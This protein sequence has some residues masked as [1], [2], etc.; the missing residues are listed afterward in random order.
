MTVP[1]QPWDSAP[2]INARIEEG[3]FKVDGLERMVFRG[4]NWKFGGCTYF[5][6]CTDCG[7]DAEAGGLVGKGKVVRWAWAH[8]CNKLEAIFADEC[9]KLFRK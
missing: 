8:K 1:H 7:K 6:V 3:F 5:V 2:T 9:Q 4:E